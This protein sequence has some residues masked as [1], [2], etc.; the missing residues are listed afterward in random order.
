MVSTKRFILNSV[1]KDY[2]D[3]H[4]IQERVQAGYLDRQRKHVP[5]TASA[6]E[7]AVTL[8]Q[9]LGPVSLNTW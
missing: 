7:A 9:N 2:I 3:V 8:L 4:F 1:Y 6:A 5:L